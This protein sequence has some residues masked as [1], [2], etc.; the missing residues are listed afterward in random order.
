MNISLKLEERHFAGFAVT[1]TISSISSQE[2]SL[3]ITLVI[4]AHL[5][6]T[7]LFS[8]CENLPE[9]QC[10]RPVCQLTMFPSSDPIEAEAL[11]ITLT[12]SPK[13]PSSWFGVAATSQMALRKKRRRYLVES[14]SPIVHRPTFGGSC[15]RNQRQGAEQCA[16]QALRRGS[17]GALGSGPRTAD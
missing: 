14:G 9:I 17:P 15:G 12:I 5:K 10:G 3:Q 8:F 2:L 16:W 6:Q 13:S 11:R 4:R 1:G 7:L